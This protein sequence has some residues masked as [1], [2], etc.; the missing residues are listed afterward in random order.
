MLDQRLFLLDPAQWEAFNAALD[1]P[2]KVNDR[3]AALL[4]RK[5]AWE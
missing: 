4:A 3:L 5:P 2:P 1:A